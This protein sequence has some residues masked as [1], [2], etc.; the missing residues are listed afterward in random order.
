MLNGFKN[1]GRIALIG[2]RSEIGRAIVDA[3]PSNP[4]REVVEVN[5]D[6]EYA[7]DISNRASREKLVAE[8]FAA[9]DV[10]IAIIAVGVLGN[11]PSLTAAENALAAMEVN[12][13]G[14]AHLTQLIAEKMK[15]QA[16]GQILVISS[17]AQVRPR[18]DNYAYGASK[19]GIDFYARGLASTLDGTGVEIK[20]LR[21]GFVRTKMTTGMQE[22]PFTI[23]ASTCGRFGAKALQGNSLVTWAPP[24]L[25]YVAFIFKLLPQPVFS[26]IASR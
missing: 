10:D 8:L 5:R 11:D 12:F 6:G 9:G 14:S 24:I 18:P 17:F 20:I 25:K 26:K 16:H 1:P 2:G 22:A 13:M 3:L 19:A 21:P 7:L 23:D 15:I 4:A